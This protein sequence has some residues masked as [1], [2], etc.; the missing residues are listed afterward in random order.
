MSRE[1]E[2][3]FIKSKKGSFTIG[4][5]KLVKPGYA[6]NYLFPYEFAVLN[7]P[8]NRTLIASIG[9]KAKK[10]DEETKATAEQVNTSLNGKTIVFQ[11]KSHDEGKLYGSISVNDI[12]SKLNIDYET[13]L[14]KHDI[15]G[16]SPI[17]EIGT[18]NLNIVIHKDISTPITVIVEKDETES[19]EVKKLNSS[20]SESAKAKTQTYADEDPV[21]DVADKNAPKKSVTIDDSVF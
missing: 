20:K 13:Q 16:F 9:K 6:F 2:V 11:A 8:Q 21:V 7:S 10:N 3:V 15:K 5:T 1:V 17:K 19:P 12:V 14:D 4:E 18:Y